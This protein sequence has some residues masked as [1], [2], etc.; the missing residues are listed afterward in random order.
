MDLSSA[1]PQFT[2]HDAATVAR[3]H[4]GFIASARPLVS[5]LDQNFLLDGRKGKAVLK[6]A[7]AAADPASVDLQQAALNHVGGAEGAP[8]CQTVIPASEGAHTVTVRGH[9]VWMVTYLEGCLLGDVN[10]R[11]SELAMSLGRMLASLDGCLSTFDHSHLDRDNAWDLRRA[12][13]L[14]EYVRYIDGD[15]RRR[16]IEAELSH[17]DSRAVPALSTLRVSPIHN[18]GNDANILVCGKGYE[19]R[20]SGVIDF[21]DMT[22]APVICE[23]AIAA[24]YAMLEVPDP[25]GTAVE[26][27]RGYH[28]EYPLQE[29]ELV[30]LR[31]LVC[32]RLCSSVL[33]SAFRSKV[34]PDND[35]L[36]SSEAPSLEACWSGL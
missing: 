28:T 18:D 36:L 21:G 32:A 5:H 2:V 30:V 10:P 19:A 29:Q 33:V 16:L 8:Q 27:V 7:N 31:D 20:A 22:R 4:F 12:P 23:V 34:E 9:T 11:T 26:V 3:D 6:I 17:F 15:D 1:A 24:T 14:L 13:D 25:V 35:Y